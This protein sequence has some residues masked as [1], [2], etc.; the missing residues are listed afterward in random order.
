MNVRDVAYLLISILV[1]VV[2]AAI[3]TSPNWDDT[4]ISIMMV[5]ISGGVL[6]FL[7]GSKPW[8]IALSV[9][10][11]IPLT[12]IYTLQNYESLFAIIPGFAGSYFGYFVSNA[13]KQ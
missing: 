12:N 13:I 4:M 11:W 7:Y 8:L 6:S 9:C 2:I 5:F 3:D 1:G 10:I